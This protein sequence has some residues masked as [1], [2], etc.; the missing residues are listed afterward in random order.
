MMQRHLDEN[1]PMNFDQPPADPFTVFEEWFHHAER[2]AGLPNPN[3]M[4]I[5]TANGDGRPTARIVLLKQFD[6][7]GFVFFTNQQSRKAEDLATNPVASLLFHWDSLERQVRI[8]GA[9]EPTSDAESDAYFDSRALESRLNAIASDQSRPIE[10]RAALD[11]RRAA[12]DA[13]HVDGQTPT[14]PP[15]WGGYRLI[16]SRFEFWSGHP[17]RLHDR[18]IY[19]ADENDGWTT[20]RLMP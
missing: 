18:V 12:V 11:A 16:P 17:H 15:H 8:E 7:R 4:T 13:E 3:A 10:N 14:R 5:A 19:V 9:I 1:P 2:H 6:A 20:T